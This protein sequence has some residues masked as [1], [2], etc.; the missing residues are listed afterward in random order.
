M[1]ISEKKQ[2]DINNIYLHN[3]D[4][5]GEKNIIEDRFIK[6]MDIIEEKFGSWIGNSIFNQQTV[7]YVL[8]ALIYDLSYGLKSK[9]VKSTPQKISDDSFRKLIHSAELIKKNGIEKV[10]EAGTRRLSTQKD[11]QILFNHFRKKN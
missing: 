4:V 8:F 2:K 7:F 5:F 11:R 10:L 3:D 6:I 1:G 9:L